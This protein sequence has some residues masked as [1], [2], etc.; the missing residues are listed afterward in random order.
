MCSSGL[1]DGLDLQMDLIDGAI[2]GMSN[3]WIDCDEIFYVYCNGSMDDFKTQLDTVEL[4]YAPGQPEECQFGAHL[5]FADASS[6]V[7]RRSSRDRLVALYFIVFTPAYCV[8]YIKYTNPAPFFFARSRID[9]TLRCLLCLNNLKMML[10]RVNMRLA[11]IALCVGVLL[12]ILFWSQCGDL[13]RRRLRPG[14]IIS[15]SLSDHNPSYIEEIEC[16]INGEYGVACK[17]ENDEIFVPF[18]F[19]HKYFEIY[20]KITSLEGVERFEWSHSY[21]KIY[22]PKKKYDPFGTFTTFENY[23]VEVR[24][25]VK[26]ISGIEGVPVSIQ[27]DPQGF[28]YPTQI[29]QFGLAHY[30]KNITEPEPRRR[31]IED[32]DR[33]LGT[34][35][36]SRDATMSREYD[37]TLKSY[38]LRFSTSDQ[39]SSQDE[40]IYYGIGTELV[41]RR[42]T[43]DLIIDMQKG[44]AV[45][46]RPKRKS[47]RTKFKI[48]SIILSG[49]GSLDNLTVSTSEHMAHFYAA[50]EWLVRKQSERTGGWPIPVRRRIASGVAELSPGCMQPTA[51]PRIY[52]GD[53][54]EWRG[55]FE[56]QRWVAC[57][58]LMHVAGSQ[59]AEKRC[60]ERL[61][62][63]PKF[64]RRHTYGAI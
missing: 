59:K 7:F 39:M 44:W 49:S 1:E 19:I 50:A 31:I 15:N 53:A 4:M 42:I 21:S 29:A 9:P 12:V 28:F 13:A 43:R 63:L 32:G 61:L 47:P 45:Q 34:W 40:H 46:D 17:K 60:A 11:L 23:N 26:C 2:V 8:L 33:N 38:V 30:S 56:G 52:S 6:Q 62:E 20:G 22:H 14:S 5:L 64:D 24:E 36:V 10:V 35:I 3:G 16:L 51:D 55:R 58:M 27:W 48:S 54:V 57:C 18:S 37:D 41:W 25:R